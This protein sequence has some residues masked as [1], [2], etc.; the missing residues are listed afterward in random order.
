[1]TTDDIAMLLRI[2][3]A[4]EQR[5]EVA[6]QQAQTA[7]VNAVKARGLAE[8]AVEDFA[9]QRPAQ[10]AAIYRPLIAGPLPGPRLRQAAAQLSGIAA[11][12]EMLRQLVAQAARHETACAQTS[13]TAQSEHAAAMRASLGAAMMHQRLD[14]AQRMADERHQDADLEEVAS[15]CRLGSRS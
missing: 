8:Q 5:A 6:L 10:E 1:M 14:A 12:G 2:K 3:R 15:R 13:A 7:R 9:Q 11:H 4:R